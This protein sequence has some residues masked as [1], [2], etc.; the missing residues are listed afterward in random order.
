MINNRFLEI[1][2]EKEDSKGLS[3]VN[4]RLFTTILLRV[5]REDK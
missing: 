1:K 3:N 5:V 2:P 4:E